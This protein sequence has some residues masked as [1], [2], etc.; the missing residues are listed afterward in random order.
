[1]EKR[2]IAAN[3]SAVKATGSISRHAILNS[4]KV[5]A[6]IMATARSARSTSRGAG[7]RPVVPSESFKARLPF[8]KIR[9]LPH[10]R[11]GP[12]DPSSVLT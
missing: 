7:D 11:M 4:V 9:D 5:D 3:R 1:M 2:N 8:H 12:R 6:H 10:G